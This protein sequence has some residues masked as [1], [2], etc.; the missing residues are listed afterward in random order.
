[1]LK[2]KLTPQAVNDL[3]EIYNYTFA[4]WGIHQAEKYQDD[5]FDWMK[6][7]TENPNIGKAYPFSKLLYRKSHINKHLIFYR[8]DDKDCIVVRVLHERMNFED[9]L[10]E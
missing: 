1:M 3:E 2:L 6:I 10:G 5:L 7:I 4:N 9:H 8:V